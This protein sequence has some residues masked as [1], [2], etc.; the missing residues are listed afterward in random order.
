MWWQ[1]KNTAPSVPPVATP[2][3]AASTRDVDCKAPEQEEPNSEA[4]P[5]LPQTAPPTPAERPKAKKPLAPKDPSQTRKA[6]E[7]E[8][9][10][11]LNFDV[12]HSSCTRFL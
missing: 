7:G 1:A 2:V 8:L 3:R 10:M 12:L 11:S 4:E 6:V 9:V 5:T